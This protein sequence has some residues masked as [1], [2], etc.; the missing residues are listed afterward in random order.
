ML[1]KHA[2][3]GTDVT[4]EDLET[5]FG[6]Y[7]CENVY[8][9]R[10]LERLLV[11]LKSNRRNDWHKLI[12]ST[13]LHLG[14]VFRFCFHYSVCFFCNSTSFQFTALERLTSLWPALKI[15]MSN[16]GD[17]SRL[18]CQVIL[19]WESQTKIDNMFCEPDNYRPNINRI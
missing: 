18:E 13:P 9:Q 15:Q 17:A 2:F 14:N 6:S 12:N 8:L 3:S 19:Q 16:Q 7:L 10:V 11:W 5:I 4:R 1:V